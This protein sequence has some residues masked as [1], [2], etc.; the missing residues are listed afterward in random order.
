[1]LYSIYFTRDFSSHLCRSRKFRVSEDV[2]L[3][4]GIKFVGGGCK[5]KARNNT[6]NE[7]KV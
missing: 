1:M 4:L 5:T 2:I 3:K 7:E 6:E